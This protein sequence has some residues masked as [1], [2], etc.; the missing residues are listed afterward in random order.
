MDLEFIEPDGDGRATFGDLRRFVKKA[1]AAGV[2][3][4]H[5]LI[6]ETDERDEVKGFSVFLPIDF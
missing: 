3:D 4:D 5:T 6:L 2:E 1:E